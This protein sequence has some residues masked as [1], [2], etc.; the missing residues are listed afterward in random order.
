MMKQLFWTVTLFLIA[1][2]RIALTAGLTV[3]LANETQL[4]G[5]VSGEIRGFV[6]DAQ[7]ESQLNGLQSSIIIQ[8]EF[9]NQ[10]ELSTAR[11]SLIPFVRLD[12]RDDRRSH[13]DLREA[14]WQHI[15]DQWTVLIGINRVFWGVTESSHLIDI[16]NQTDL[17]ENIDGEEKLGQPMINLATQQD[18]GNVSLFIMPWFRERTF[19]SKQGRL[20]SQP[21]A[22]Q[23]SLY[24]STDGQRHLDMALRY[25]HYIG[26][27]DFGL[28]YFKGTSREPR[29]LLNSNGT[30]LVAQYDLIDQVGIDIQLTNDAWL[31]KFEGIVR[32]QNGDRFAAIVSGFE[33]TLYQVANSATDLGL[34]M[35]YSRDGR[36]KNPSKTPPVV[37]DDAIFWAARL[38]VND[39]QN[40]ELLA[41][42]VVD[43]NDGSAILSIEAKRRLDDNWSIGLESRWFLKTKENNSLSPFRKDSFVTFRLARYF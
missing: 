33:Y 39:T 11:I 38:A 6:S 7:F 20:R 8:P 32:S 4:S 28:Y 16:I 3:A 22:S 23:N 42:V 36:N 17:V 24:E 37:F 1:F 2:P 30:Q 18:R 15:D 27:W 40:S 29:F 35:E 14:Y 26:D 31:W 41:G 12:S 25:S 10:P 21:V 5:F 9:L 43:R 19:P 13:A 34:L